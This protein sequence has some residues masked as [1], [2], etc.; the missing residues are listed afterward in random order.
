MSAASRP[1]PARPAAAP[2]WIGEP[3]PRRRGNVQPLHAPRDHAGDQEIVA[4]K[5]GERAGDP[6]LVARDDGGVRNGQ[7]ERVAE[8]RGHCE[9][10]GQA[11][12]H[13]G[14]G[15]GAHE[16][17]RGVDMLIMA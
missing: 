2:A 10:V 17:D 13:R 8:Q 4:Q 15:K 14:F 3:P 16:P 12:H 9:P 11:A 1:T 7:M 5:G 6:V